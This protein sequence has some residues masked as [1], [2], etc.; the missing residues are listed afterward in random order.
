MA[1]SSITPEQE[2]HMFIEKRI[3][4]KFLLREGVKPAE[5]LRWLTEQFAEETLS[6]TQVY[7]WHKKIHDGREPV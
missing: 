6:R 2:M 4:I 7:E 5:I 1:V 3:I